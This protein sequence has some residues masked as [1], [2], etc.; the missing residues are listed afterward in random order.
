MEELNDDEF[1]ETA[2]SISFANFTSVGIPFSSFQLTPTSY[3]SRPIAG[4][5]KTRRYDFNTL[6]DKRFASLNT[7]LDFEQGGGIQ[8]LVNTYNPDSSKLVDQTSASSQEDY[9]RSFPVRKVAVGADVEFRSL[10]GRPIIK[11]L[12]ID[13]ILVGRDT[14]NKE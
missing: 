10:Q 2:S 3:E 13:A 1:G 9:T 11:S 14:K 6:E 12:T 7:D 4:Y 5:A 8:T